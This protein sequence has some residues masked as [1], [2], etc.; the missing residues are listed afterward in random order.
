MIYG[1]LS[2]KESSQSS[3]TDGSSDETDREDGH[4]GSTNDDSHVK[5][6][7]EFFP[8]ST[9]ACSVQPRW[10]KN[11]RPLLPSTGIINEEMS[12]NT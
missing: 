7:H 1:D 2:E 9:R 3:S 12:L 6:N 10:R 4:E 8:T 11:L 5:D